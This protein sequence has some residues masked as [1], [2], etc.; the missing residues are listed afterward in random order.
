MDNLD[1]TQYSSMNPERETS[2]FR[3][4]GDEIVSRIANGVNLTIKIDFANH[5]IDYGDG[6]WMYKVE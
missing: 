1:I 3:I 4:E 5:T 6:N 2:T